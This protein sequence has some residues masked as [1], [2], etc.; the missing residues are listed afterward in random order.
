MLVPFRPDQLGGVIRIA[1]AS[2]KAAEVGVVALVYLIAVLSISVGLM[3]LFPIPLLDGGHLLFY[4][5]EA[6]RGKQ[7]SKASQGAGFKIGLAMVS[8][9]M[10]FAMWNDLAVVARWLDFAAQQIQSQ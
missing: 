7:L 10:V 9:L 5:L 1:D 4:A 3:N 6:A 2:G 8:S